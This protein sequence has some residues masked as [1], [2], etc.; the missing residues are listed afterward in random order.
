[1]RWEGHLVPGRGLEPPRCYPLVP[2]TSASTNS[3]TRA[4]SGAAQCTHEVGSCQLKG[5]R[6]KFGR[7]DRGKALDA[8]TPS[9]RRPEAPHRKGAPHQGKRG[10]AGKPNRTAE[11]TVS[12]NRAGYG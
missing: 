3:A 2:E 6:G 1:M 11:G 12:A 10:E 8:K 5:K 4:M 9:G 7:R